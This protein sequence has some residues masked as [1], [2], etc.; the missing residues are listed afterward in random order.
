MSD[1]DDLM[2]DAIVSE[3]VEETAVETVTEQKQREYIKRYINS[4]PVEERVN[5][6]NIIV[7]NN[8]KKLLKDCKEGT[9]VNLNNV[10]SFIIRQMYDLLKYKIDKIE[11]E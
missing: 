9:L 11:S 6:V 7:F 4:L 5:V 3:T 10:P 8:E 1:L 2:L